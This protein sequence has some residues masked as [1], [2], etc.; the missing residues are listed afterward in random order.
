MVILRKYFGVRGRN[1]STLSVSQL[2][3]V[4]DELADAE[5]QL[6]EANE[7]AATALRHKRQQL[8]VART[9]PVFLPSLQGP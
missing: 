6:R 7:A 5:R 8:Q 4:K 3:K 9:A 2:V 1:Y